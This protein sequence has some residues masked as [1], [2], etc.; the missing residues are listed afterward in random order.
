MSRTIA[1]GSPALPG[2]SRRAVANS[3]ERLKA[4]AIAAAP[5]KALIVAGVQRKPLVSVEAPVGAVLGVEVAE[6]ARPVEVEA[7]RVVV[8]AGRSGMVSGFR[9]TRP[10]TLTIEFLTE[11]K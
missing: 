3:L 2:R 8:A 11:E 6:E 10:S 7:E 5:L 4:R 9:S 1:N